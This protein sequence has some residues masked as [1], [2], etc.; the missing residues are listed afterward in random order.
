MDTG[1]WACQSDAK[2]YRKNLKTAKDF[3]RYVILLNK[4]E[5]CEGRAQVFQEEIS[6]MF[7]WRFV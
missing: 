1:Y 5:W 2:V 6:T 3:D 4:L 7:N